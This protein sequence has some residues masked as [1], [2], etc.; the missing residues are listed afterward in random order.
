MTKA[1]VIKDEKKKKL[2][3]CVIRENKKHEKS[4]KK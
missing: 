4:W 2:I 1:I 3:Y